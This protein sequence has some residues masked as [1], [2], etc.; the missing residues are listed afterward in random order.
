MC[1]NHFAA[2]FILFEGIHDRRIRKAS[3]IGGMI[4]KNLSPDTFG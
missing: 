4:R 3:V 2:I 1:E